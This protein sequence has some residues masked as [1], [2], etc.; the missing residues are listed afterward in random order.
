MIKTE[1]RN[2]FANNMLADIKLSKAYLSKIIQSGGFLG[3]ML[4]RFAGPLMKVVVT[5][6]KNVLTPLVTMV[7]ASAMNGAIQRKIHG[8]GVVR[9][10][11]GINL[12]ILNE[13]MGD[14]RIIKKH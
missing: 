3:T 4:A 5:L 7:S 2:A 10:R 14:I 12:V 13:D 6:G 9:A 8:R 11:K 1:I